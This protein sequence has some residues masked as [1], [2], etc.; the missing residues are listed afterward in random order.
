MT[1]HDINPDD[2][3]GK[4]AATPRKLRP[5]VRAALLFA[6]W[7]HQ[8]GS[9]PVG[10]PIRAIL[11]IGQ[12][13]SLVGADLVNA[14][15]VHGLLSAPPNPV[16]KVCPL[17]F[18]AGA[19]TSW[20]IDHPGLPIG[21]RLFLG[22]QGPDPEPE[23]QRLRGESGVL[24]QLLRESLDVLDTLEPE[25]DTENDEL[26]KLRGQITAALDLAPPDG[27]EHGGMTCP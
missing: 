1:D 17:P 19:S 8:G 7:H 22:P 4:L 16:A 12:H 2:P 14:Q 27:I 13:D 26:H 3:D 5:E 6:L 24:R 10:Q 15:R 23:L 18:G 11:G 21:T 20:A 9:S 25:D